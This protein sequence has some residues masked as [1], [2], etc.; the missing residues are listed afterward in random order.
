[1]DAPDVVE[2]CRIA[3]PGRGPARSGRNIALPRGRNSA[4]RCNRRL[5]SARCFHPRRTG[6]VDHRQLAA[7]NRRRNERDVDVVG[8]DERH[9]DELQGRALLVL[10]RDVRHLHGVGSDQ[11]DDHLHRRG[12][13]PGIGLGLWLS[14][15]REPGN[16]VD[17]AAC[18][19]RHRAARRTRDAH[20]DVRQ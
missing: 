4:G 8:S 14:H 9:T 17:R 13:G 11:R 7:R 3:E 5:G 18:T 15:H 1:M 20:R 16:N 19:D 6:A 2:R 12:F 10:R